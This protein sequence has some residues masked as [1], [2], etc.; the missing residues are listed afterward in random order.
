MTMLPPTRDL[1][2][3]RQSQIRASLERSVASDASRGSVL[4]FA[5]P[6]L[7]G[8]FV[9]AAVTVTVV[10]FSPT[11]PTDVDTAELT[12]ALPPISDFGL[13][14]DTLQQIVEGCAKD[15]KVPGKLTLHQFVRDDAGRWALL[16]TDRS[17]VNCDIGRRGKEYDASVQD[18]PIAWL[19]GHFSLDLGGSMRGGDSPPAIPAS[20]GMP[21]YYVVMGRVDKQVARMTYTAADGRTAEAKIANGTFS[22]RIAYPSTWA[23]MDGTGKSD[24]RAYD[25]AGNLL[26]TFAEQAEACHYDPNTKAIVYGERDAA[27]PT[28]CK[29][30]TPWK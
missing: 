2:P 22:A 20:Q 23:G 19:P 9:V 17:V 4:R 15:A 27:D 25:A 10:K 18:V 12:S 13:T 24:L 14:P 5:L 28:K 30:A 1:P 21:G 8:A 29:P 3:G 26:G 16:Y 6:A 7:A 11:A